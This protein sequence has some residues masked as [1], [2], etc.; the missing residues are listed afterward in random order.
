MLVQVYEI[1]SDLFELLF[2]GP[3]TTSSQIVDGSKLSTALNNLSLHGYRI[4]YPSF[5]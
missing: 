5:C 1:T 2:V 4:E 3:S